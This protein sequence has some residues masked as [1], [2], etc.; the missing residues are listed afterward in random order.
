MLGVCGYNFSFD[1]DAMNPMIT[2]LNGLTNTQIQN[3][4]FDHYNVTRYTDFPYTTAIPTEWDFGTIMDA[5]FNGNIHAGNVDFVLEQVSSIRIKRRIKGTFDWITW[6]DI[7]VST[8]DDLKFSKNDNF[9]AHEVEYEYAFVPVLN[10]VEGNYIVNSI[11]SMLSGVFVCDAQTIYKFYAGVSYGGTTQVQKT[12]V[13]EPI[14]RKYPVVISNA[15]TNYQTGSMNGTI[16]PPDFLENRTLDRGAMVKTRQMLNEFL[17][18]R[19]AKM[20]KDW[21]GN[22]WMVVIV[23]GTTTSYN[24]S[25]GMGLAD[26]GFNWV[27]QGDPNNKLDLYNN[28]L[29]EVIE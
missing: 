10:N 15:L 28:G 18:N 12:G 22:I 7:P 19:R 14:G 11:F 9:N 1:K 29:I 3:G 13:L 23:N 17:T 4:V 26:I 20:I 24:S 2:S 27:E 25:Y 21:N 5:N 6:F 8:L 16:L